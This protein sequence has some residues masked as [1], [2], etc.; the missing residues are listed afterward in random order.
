[1]KP[2]LRDLLKK[3]TTAIPNVERYTWLDTM[4]YSQAFLAC[5][6]AGPWKIGRRRLIQKT[7]I[8]SLGD[9]DLSVATITPFPL[10][11]QNRFLSSMQGFLRETSQTME[12]VCVGF[13][14][15]DRTYLYRAAGC[16]KGAKVLSL[17]CRDKLHIPAFP[18][19]RHV[20]RVLQEHG[21]PTKE[22]ELIALCATEGL[23]PIETATL[24]IRY[25]SGDTKGE[26]NP[27]D[28]LDNTGVKA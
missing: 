24:I 28:L 9:K 18:V 26:L 8:Q 14:G 23:D 13:K 25:A 4:N 19:D 27:M 7:A 20:R 15:V 16:P 11:W 10:D 1:M 22:A 17:F 6:G 12:E 2:A 5:I 21:L 3:A